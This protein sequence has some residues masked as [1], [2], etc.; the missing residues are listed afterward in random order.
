MSKNLSDHRREYQVASTLSSMAGTQ[1]QRRTLQ[2]QG[3]QALRV[4]LITGYHYL[5]VPSGTIVP[6]YAFIDLESSNANDIMIATL[7]RSTFLHYT[8]G[9]FI[10]AD[11]E[12]HT[13]TDDFWEV[14]LAYDNRA[15]PADLSIPYAPSGTLSAR[16]ATTLSAFSLEHHRA[17]IGL[18]VNRVNS[19][20]KPASVDEYLIVYQI[21]ATI[22]G[23]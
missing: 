19:T 5:A 15:V 8:D 11:T 7:L 17:R 9:T 13:L 23:A 3:S 21:R 12:D 14:W 1:R 2:P 4:E 6:N 16:I 20:A 18:R 22:G 10:N